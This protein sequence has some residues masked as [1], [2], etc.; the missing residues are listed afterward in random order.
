M[1]KNFPYQQLKNYS[2][3]SRNLQIQIENLYWVRKDDTDS[4]FSDHTI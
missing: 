1:T 3:M 4:N 2:N